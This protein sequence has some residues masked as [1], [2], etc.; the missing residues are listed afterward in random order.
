MIASAAYCINS[1]PLAEAV[2]IPTVTQ[3]WIADDSAAGGQVDPTLQWWDKLCQLGPGHGYVPNAAKTKAILKNLP[4][5]YQ[6]LQG[7]GD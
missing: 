4:R 1:R 2:H 3:V 7:K 5:E 6:R